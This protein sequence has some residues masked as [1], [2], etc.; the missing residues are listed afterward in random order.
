VKTKE[1]L[2]QQAYLNRPLHD[3]FKPL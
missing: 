1:S 3:L 2:A